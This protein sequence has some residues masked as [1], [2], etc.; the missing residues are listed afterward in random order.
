MRILFSE[1]LHKY[2]CPE[3]PNLNFISVSTI[4]GK[5]HE[6]FDREAK[7]ISSSKKTGKS[8]EQLLQEWDEANKVAVER[9]TKFHLS[10]EEALLKK[11]N[12]IKYD[13]DPSSNLKMS[14]DITQL[15]PGIYP[16]LILYDLEH[17]IVGT[18]D[19]VEIFPDKTF[20]LEDYKTN[21]ELS[22]SGF[23]VFDPSTNTR[24]EKKMYSPLTHLADC[25]GIHYSLQ[26]SI[27]A[28]MLER[29]GYNLRPNGLTVHHILFD[30]NNNPVDRVLYP[31]NYLKKEV[32]SLFSH[33][34]KSKK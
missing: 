34:L 9:G 13:T 19:Y 23:K 1:E 6:K 32:K 7:A 22:F 20:I 26:L 25:N 11:K 4:I 30:E 31:I 18:A 27:Y 14:F 21:K 24:K 17:G 16:E 12:V 8:K 29:A 10:Q 28:Y 33:Y 15:K 3:L 2:H 5:Y